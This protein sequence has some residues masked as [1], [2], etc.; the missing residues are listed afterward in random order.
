ML[1]LYNTAFKISLERS[2]LNLWFTILL[3]FYF[4]VNYTLVD[5]TKLL[6]YT[7]TRGF[8]C[9]WGAARRK[10]RITDCKCYGIYRGEGR[11]IVS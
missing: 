8:Y 11:G 7:R 1:L 5:D 10:T 6:F 4:S 9:R 2:S 3:T